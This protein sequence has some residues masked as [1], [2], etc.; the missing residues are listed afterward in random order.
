MFECETKFFIIISCQLDILFETTEDVKSFQ[1]INIFVNILDGQTC[2]ILESQH[3]CVSG[4]VFVVSYL[5]LRYLFYV[6]LFLQLAMQPPRS[7]LV[8]SHTFLQNVASRKS[9]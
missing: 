2:I 7:M 5:Y 3:I 8:V 6:C 1:Q 9:K 4:F